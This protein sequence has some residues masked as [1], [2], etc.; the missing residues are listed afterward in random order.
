MDRT[1]NPFSLN[2]HQVRGQ[3]SRPFCADIRWRS[4]CAQRT[5]TVDAFKFFTKSEESVLIASLTKTAT[6]D[7]CTVSDSGLESQF[8]RLTAL[9]ENWWLNR[10]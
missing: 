4:R 3:N 6:V 8:S 1:H 10:Q 9:P 2:P 7:D 5:C